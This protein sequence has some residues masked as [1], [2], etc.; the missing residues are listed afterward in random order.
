[1]TDETDPQIAALSV[2]EKWIA[3]KL[4]EHGFT[5]EQL[6]EL[7]PMAEEVALDWLR[8]GHA[9]IP[10]D[11][12]TSEMKRRTK[13]RFTNTMRPFFARLLRIRHPELRSAIEVATT[14][15]G[16]NK[17]LK[18]ALDHLNVV[19]VVVEEKGAEGDV[20]ERRTIELAEIPAAVERA[21]LARTAARD[22][23]RRAP[24]EPANLD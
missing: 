2:D 24:P 19:A 10:I 6:E 1:M 7:Y 8:E 11:A 21:K 4:S 23:D 18:V 13:R 15:R 17:N 16:R 9:R 3:D 14:S 20:P 5:M 12:V 22:A